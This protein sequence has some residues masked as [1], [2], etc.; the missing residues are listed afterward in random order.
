MNMSTQLAAPPSQVS[1]WIGLILFLALCLAAG[2]LGSIATTPE[3]DGWY[4]TL[5][6]PSFTPPNYLF[7]PVWTTL[8]VLMGVAAWW[9]WKQDGF[10]GAPLALGLFFVQLGFNVAW[11]W[12]FFAG[13]APGWAFA[14]IILLWLV[15]AA[16]L[17]LFLARSTLAGCL[18]VPYLAWVSYAGALNFAIWRLNS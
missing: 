13:H 17:G 8:Y 10:A 5:E 14:E 15:I 11:S 4:Q 18:L 2:G 7:G 9:V 1:T 12:I 16:T 6:K 3:I